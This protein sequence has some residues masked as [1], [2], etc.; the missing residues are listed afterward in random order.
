MSPPLP[1]TPSRAPMETGVPFP[2]PMVYSFIHLSEAPVKELSYKMQGK[3]KVTAHGAPRGRTAYMQ[4]GAPWFPKWIF[5]DTAVTTPV[6]CRLRHD[7][8]HLGLRRPEPR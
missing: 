1:C 5:N 6:T 4:W 7:T 8:F 2:E 3:H